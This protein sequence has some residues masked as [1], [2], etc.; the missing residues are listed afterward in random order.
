[1]TGEDNNVRKIAG[2]LLCCLIIA[3]AFL[4]V[5]CSADNPGNAAPDFELQ[6]LDGQT[7]SLSDYRGSPVMLNF[8]ASWCSPCRS[9]MPYLQDIFEDVKWQAADLVILAVNLGEYRSEAGGFMD[10]SG[11]TFTVLLDG[12]MEVA[13][14]YNIRSIPTTFFIDERGIIKHMDIGS[15]RS[16]ADLEQRLSDLIFGE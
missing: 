2:L 8:W 7:V 13:E 16:K 5:N 4:A 11:Y 6:T 12:K 9:E 10:T 1:L 14:M 15:F 3:I